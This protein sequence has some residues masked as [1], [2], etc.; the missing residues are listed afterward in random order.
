[1]ELAN[2]QNFEEIFRALLE[3]ATRH[4]KFWP[5]QVPLYLRELFWR[6][7]NGYVQGSTKFDTLVRRVLESN[8]N[9]VMFLNLN[10]DLFL[11][12]AIANYDQY[13]FSNINS[14][15]PCSRKWRY[16]KPHGSV[17][18]A[19]ILEN[20]PT[21]ASGWF[22]PSR[23]QEVPVFSSELLLVMWNTHS[24]DFYVP[25]GGPPGYLYPQLVVPT[26][27]PKDFVCPE[28]HLE[29]AR[30]FV[31]NCGHFLVIGF[32]GRDEHILDFL[33]GVPSNSCWWIV[34]RGDAR[35]IYERFRC[36]IGSLKSGNAKVY[37]NDMG[38]S[39]FVER[40]AFEQFLA[41]Q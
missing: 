23:L 5:L 22:F 37:F 38:F 31:K 25:G 21:D 35:A 39:A 6:I 2:D 20:C 27:R 3:S 24:G 13:E 33:Q 10:Y 15:M 11:E 19:R 16:M 26:D 40:A 32:S 9:E 34:S 41:D 1:M 7:T 17:N 12:D 28:A 8:F 14:Y 30:A 29:T 36:R 4:R 18:W